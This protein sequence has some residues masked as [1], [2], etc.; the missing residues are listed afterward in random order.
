M[1]YPIYSTLIQRQKNFQ[2]FSIP[3]FWQSPSKL[4]GGDN[5]K[6]QGARGS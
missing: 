5:P 4:N 2:T 6:N 3:K 1:V